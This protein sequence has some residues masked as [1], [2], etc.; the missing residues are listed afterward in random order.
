MERDGG[1]NNKRTAQESSSAFVY[2][3][4]LNIDCPGGIEPCICGKKSQR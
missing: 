1:C 4:V 2:R 3:I